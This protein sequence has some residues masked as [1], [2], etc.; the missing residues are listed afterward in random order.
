MD[1]R[2]SIS[3]LMTKER[4]KGSVPTQHKHF[5]DLTLYLPFM[6]N[7][8]Y[9]KMKCNGLQWRYNLIESATGVPFG[10]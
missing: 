2:K 10:E 6:A 7:I 5:L 1:K 3:A 4:I 8:S 9:C